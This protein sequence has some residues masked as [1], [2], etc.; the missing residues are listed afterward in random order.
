M[1][2]KFLIVFWGKIM[3]AFTDN[4]STQSNNTEPKGKRG[5]ISDYDYLFNNVPTK[6]GK[7]KNKFLGKLFK[8]NGG[9]IALTSFIY[10]FQSAP[11][12]IIPL[13][14]ANI[15][16]VVTD[17]LV[18]GGVFTAEIWRILI[19]NAAIMFVSI[20]Q[21]VP[22]TILRLKIVNKMLRTTSAGIKTSVVKKLQGLSITYHKEMQAG[23][24]HSKFIKD[25]DSVEMFLRTILC[26]IVPNVLSAIAAIVVSVINN[27]WV[28][29]FF[30]F[31][32]P[33]NVGLSLMFRKKIRT[34]AKDYRVK[35][36]DMSAKLNTM[37]EMVPVTKSHGLEQVEIES[38]RGSIS[39]LTNSG[40][41]MDKAISHFGSMMWVVNNSLK[42]LCLVFCV[43]LAVFGYIKVGDIVLYQSMFT[44]ISMY[45]TALVDML[46]QITTG[47]EAVRSVSEIM[48][49]TDMEVNSGKHAVK[50]IEGRVDFEKVSYR[51]PDKERLVIKDF[52]LSVKSGECIAV[53][54]ASG[55]GKSTLMNMIIG[56]LKPTD[57][58]LKID[59]KSIEELNLSEYRHHISVVPQSSVLFSGTIRENI[60]YGLV[61]YDQKYFDRVVD[62]A[63]LNEFVKDLPDGL[64][65]NI[66]EHGDKISGGQKQRITIA[67]ALIRNPKI[68][69]L[70][71]ATSALDNISE[72][73]V[74]KAIESAI[75]D[76]TTFIVAHR[77]STIRGADRIIV[78]DNGEICESG[79][80]E[81]L[82]A[83]KGKFYE[84]KC[85]NE[86]NL[87]QAEE[88]LA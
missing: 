28:A 56:F 86:M 82:M 21:N 20:L 63:N 11:L 48:N 25:T 84:L 9:N 74:Q 2:E 60:T 66:G 43:V 26:S 51:Y 54:G 12:W 69:I 8:M 75:K 64:D 53:V 68:L 67:R 15:I 13:V 27:G 52:N 57:G 39:S 16:N 61:N 46:P 7:S 80:Y 24:I 45:I 71:E 81:E 23:K 76:R 55:S 83:K 58:T 70:D 40:L 33:C 3:G 38:M 32:I 37:I 72:Y 18:S 34:R 29:L 42:A 22:T 77:L 49:V 5:K 73:H 17:T 41:K 87:K 85:L 79:T 19:I 47:V 6:K 4:S 78:M 10:L 50:D 30:L 65:T 1:L 88:S 36:E 59:G 44:S 35:T 31:V 14:T 62:M